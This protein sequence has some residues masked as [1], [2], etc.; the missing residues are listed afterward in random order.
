MNSLVTSNLDKPLSPK[1]LRRIWIERLKSIL[2]DGLT[3]RAVRGSVWMTAG[4]AASQLIRL[5]SNLVLARLLFPE[6]FG[7]M[8]IVHV[9]QRGMAMFSDVGI[10]PSII[11]NKEGDNPEFL[12][13]AWTLQVIRG[14]LLFLATCVLSRYVALLYNQPMLMQ[15]IPVAGFSAVIAGFNPTKLFT[16]KRHLALGRLT[17]VELSS[18]ITSVAAAVLLAWWTQSV[19]AL[20]FGGLIGSV[21]KLTLAHRIIPGAGNR[22]AW[23]PDTARQLIRFG[24]WIFLSSLVGFLANQGDKLVLAAFMTADELGVYSIAFMLA[25]AIWTANSKINQSVLFPIYSRRQDVSLDEMRQM[26]LRARIG[27]CSFLL[28]PLLVLI[29]AGDAVVRLLYDSRYWEAGWMLQALSAGFAILVG[30]NIGPFYLAKGNSKLYMM[31]IAINAA[32]LGGCMTIG[33]YL[34]SVTGIVYG[35]AGARLVSY[36]I[37]ASVYRHFGLW[38]WKLDMIV[39][40]CIALCGSYVI[41][42]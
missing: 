15:L 17:I 16:T 31:L 37:Q 35:I 22:F 25:S 8:A 11:Q 34:G 1:G 24:K 28:P 40:A 30:T 21:L 41:W 33:G 18:Q 20:V 9:F 39:L 38:I 19:W 4:Y 14:L 12:N 32:I 42:M 13:T 7:L 3:A 36:P 5:A 27:L 23:N 10:G 2:G 26:V 29:V 6:A